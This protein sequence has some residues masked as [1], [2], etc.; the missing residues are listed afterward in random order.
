M[1][2]WE[3]YSLCPTALGNPG[4][5]P[6]FWGIGVLLEEL[7]RTI[8]NFSNVWDL[9]KRG[10]QGG[11]NVIMKCN[12]DITDNLEFE[13][14][15]EWL[16]SRQKC[17]LVGKSMSEVMELDP[18]CVRAWNARETQNLQAYLRRPGAHAKMAVSLNQ[19]PE[20]D[21]GADFGAASDHRR[22]G[23]SYLFCLTK[24][25]AQGVIYCE[26]RSMTVQSM[27]QYQCF[28]IRPW[29]AVVGSPNAHRC[30]SF[31]PKVLRDGSIDATVSGSSVHPV[32]WPKHRALA[33]KSEE[34]E[35]H[36]KRGLGSCHG[37]G[38]AHLLVDKLAIP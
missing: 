7:G 2:T 31:C 5:R 12:C 33:E 32:A 34:G 26:G 3:C 25:D 35:D 8:C 1:W 10:W 19:N 24:K 37:T 18:P 6:R 15:L 28:P 22:D 17:P 29:Q 9:G 11:F 23:V 21:N 30:T 16:L 13:D 36:S 38:L 20:A 14:E 4:R 27:L